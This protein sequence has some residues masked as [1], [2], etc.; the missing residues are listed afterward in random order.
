M[1]RPSWSIHVENFGPVASG[2]ITLA[3]LTILAGRN[4]TGKSYV[5][6]LLWALLNPQA[7]LLPAIDHEWPEYKVCAEWAGPHVEAAI[8]FE[9]II[10]DVGAFQALINR[11]LIERKDEIFGKFMSQY[12]IAPGHINWRFEEKTFHYRPFLNDSIRTNYMIVTGVLWSLLG[13]CCW[14]GAEYL[15]AARTGLM[16]AYRPLIDGLLQT[17]G[18]SGK[19]YSGSLS[20]PVIQFLQIINESKGVFKDGT[21]LKGNVIESIEEII[22]GKIGIEG[23]DGAFFYQPIGTTKKLG[24]HVSSSLVTELAP[25]LILLKSKNPQTIIF[26][27]PEAHLHLAA[28]RALARALGRLVNLGKTI[29]ITTHSDIFLQEINNLMHLYVHPDKDDLLKR[30]GYS[31]EELIQPSDARA[32]L[33]QNENGVTHIRAMEQKEEGF[34]NPDMNSVLS[35]V[36]EMTL[37]LQEQE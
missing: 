15:P 25:F 27:E 26:E 9:E 20:L 21:D 36:A 28:Q 24:L 8:D 37:K 16:L 3:P 13:W 10:N 30:F 34:V 35:S 5:S 12:G 1:S 17:F 18:R 32:Y 22:G 11:A 14:S 7:V 33:F 4:N 2:T 6:S 29:I 31:Q 23:A 19:N